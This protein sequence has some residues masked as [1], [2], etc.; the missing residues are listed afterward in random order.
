MGISINELIDP[1]L[2]L[3]LPFIRIAAFFHFCPVF[4]HRAFPHKAKAGLA[5]LLSILITPMLDNNVVLKELMS[6]QALLLTGEQLLWGLLF[7]QML[8]WVFIALQTAGAILSMNMGLGMAVMNDPGSGSSTM[9]ISQIV[10][11]FTILL[12]FSVDG[13]LLLL[14]ILY[15][16]F[17]YWP[18]GQA[19]NTLT[20]RTVTTGVGW[21]LTSA[22]L[23]A[24]PTV[25]IMLLVQGVF[26]LLNRISPTLNLF[27][28]GFPISMLFGL[29]CL[30]LLS[31]SIPQHYLSLTN[32]ILLLFD[33][34]RSH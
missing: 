11:V 4:E 2:A 28:L 3:W 10:F 27:A 5:L 32:Q 31:G 14:T 23:L 7:G 1:L 13:H 30:M 24:L 9:V 17:A 16:G 15:K 26:G 25:F 22:V 8:N 20:L 18:I 19:I 34:L 33:S 12:F 29:F 6:V 21:L